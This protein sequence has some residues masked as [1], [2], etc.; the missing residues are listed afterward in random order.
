MGGAMHGP[1]DCPLR[2]LP[3]VPPAAELSHFVVS[4]MK[5]QCSK[6]VSASLIGC[7]QRFR[8]LQA[9]PF[10]HRY[11]R[12]L[13]LRNYLV[14]IRILSLRNYLLE[15]CMRFQDRFLRGRFGCLC[16]HA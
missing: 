1:R 4:K 7:F 6:I 2:E 12:I 5:M 11:R 15:I 9:G 3:M 8:H 10:E 16:V 13:S 14:E